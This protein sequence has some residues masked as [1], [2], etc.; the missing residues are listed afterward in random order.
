MG[1]KLQ[2]DL[3]SYKL[4]DLLSYGLQEASM[5][6]GELPKASGKE[7]NCCSCLW[8]TLDWALSFSEFAECI[9]ARSYCN[10]L[11]PR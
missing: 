3:V 9:Q 10:V 1:Q 6:G 2:L 8:R 11:E 4:L 7:V 5:V